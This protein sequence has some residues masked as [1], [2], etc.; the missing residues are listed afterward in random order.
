MACLPED[1]RSIAST[2]FRMRNYPHTRDRCFGTQSETGSRPAARRMYEGA[3][4]CPQ[5]QLGR[6]VS[7]P[8]GRHHL[9][10]L[11]G[12]SSWRPASGTASKR[13]RVPSGSTAVIRLQGRGTVTRFCIERSAIW[14]YGGSTVSGHCTPAALVAAP[15]CTRAGS[16]IRVRVQIETGGGAYSRAQASQW[17]RIMSANPEMTACDRLEIQPKHAANFLSAP[18]HPP[19]PNGEEP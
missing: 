16:W 9:C 13:W 10:T 5:R 12:S 19:R 18:T 2:N 15:A 4:F 17:R 7:L 3:G 11:G 14:G 8:Y 1:T 6:L